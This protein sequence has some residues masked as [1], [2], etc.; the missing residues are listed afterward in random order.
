MSGRGKDAAE[1]EKPYP[2]VEERVLPAVPR[3]FMRPARRDLSDLPVLLPGTVLVFHHGSRYVAFSESTPLT[4]AEE[5]VADATAV[6][7]VDVRA[8][9]FT[10]Y[11][12]LPT[13]SAADD[14]T[15]R[16]TFRARV[17]DPER[18]AEHGPLAMTRYLSSYLGQDPRLGKLGSGYS[19][20][21]IN[22][23]R[24]L[25]I[26]RIEAYCEFHPI[27]LPGLS[28][29]LDS[30]GVQTPPVLRQ[31]ERDKRDERW[32]QEIDQLK[33][34]GED[35]S[36]KRHKQWVEEGPTALT[37]VGLARDQVP[38]SEAIQNA[39]DDEQRVQERFAEAFRILQQNG[40]M[41]YLD[42]DPTDMVRA[43]LEKLTGQ[44]VQRSRRYGLQADGASK[45]EALG[46]GSDDEDDEQPDEASLDE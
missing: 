25:V 3:R 42:I 9:D 28:V 4:G 14:F 6:A 35:V 31:H 12:P 16:A 8:R 21:D 45:H 13:A 17:T 32:Q 38:V 39:R 40:G 34:D 2:V 26:S 43:Y 44:P 23:V 30:A 24:D 22:T 11:F 10:I 19:I 20:E 27:D 36:I 41:D 33:A 29:E 46:R 5:P 7:L 15:V 18:A 37:A 1:T